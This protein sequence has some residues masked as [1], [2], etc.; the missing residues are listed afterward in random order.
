M[1]GFL[2]RRLLEMVPTV[3]AMSL[4]IFAIVAILPGDVTL[5]LLGEDST[6]EQREVLRGQLGLN[7]PLYVQYFKWLAGA[8]TGDLGS[9]LRSGEPVLSIVLDRAPVTI[10]LTILSI[11]IA[12]LIGVPTGIYAALHR[13]T[14]GDVTLR[15]LALA[16]VAIPNFWLGIMLILLFSLWLGLLPPS[17]YRPFFES[18]LD[19]LRLMIL[20]ALTMGTG[21]AAVIMRQTRASMLEVLNKDYI[22][23][24]TAKGVS[25][26]EI[27]RRH[28]LPNSLIPVITVTGLQIGALM[29]GAVITEVVFSL[30]GVGRMA[31]D[32]VFTRD[33][34]VIQG[35]IVVIIL[36]VL[37]VNLITDLVYAY[38]D[39]RIKV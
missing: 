18:P 35:A 4:V 23:T 31:A 39:P 3:F 29:N 37:V 26:G 2:V 36:A 19:S 34:P 11:I 7:D 10:Q 17:G 27:I 38:V 13:N 25:S 8:V 1:L 5:S 20:P 30:P 6:R 24:A 28:A 15:T 33:I 9:S 32:A 12:L 21:L 16:G 22:K 14:F